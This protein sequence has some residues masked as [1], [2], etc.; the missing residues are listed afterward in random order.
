MLGRRVFETVAMQ[1]PKGAN[2]SEWKEE[3]RTPTPVTIM[4]EGPSE[5]ESKSVQ[6]DRA[7]DNEDREK[8]L[9][10]GQEAREDAEGQERE[11]R[12][13]IGSV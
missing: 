3:T 4:E 6:Q 10:A 8:A 12:R 11:W 7:I 5:E 1:V 13:G 9:D 2:I